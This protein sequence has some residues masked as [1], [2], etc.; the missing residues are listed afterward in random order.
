MAI[1]SQPSIEDLIALVERGN[2]EA[3]NAGATSS[4]ITMAHWHHML[5]S[6]ATITTT[7]TT[8]T[9]VAHDES[10]ASTTLWLVQRSQLYLIQTSAVCLEH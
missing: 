3:D 6:E 9:Q 8:T 10:R 2:A 7:T 5:Y 4:I 1:F